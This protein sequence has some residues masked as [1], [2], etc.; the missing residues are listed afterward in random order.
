MM[1]NQ[2]SAIGMND[3]FPD[4]TPAAEMEKLADGAF[5]FRRFAVDSAESIVQ[6][7]SQIAKASPFRHMITPGGYRM[8]VAMTNCGGAGWT[9][10]RKTAML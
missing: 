7:V 8:S 10:D 1:P 3:L 9:T 2:R 4:A 6:A 5:L